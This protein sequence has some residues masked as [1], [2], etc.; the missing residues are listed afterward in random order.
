M[1]AESPRLRS[2]RLAA[3][4]V[5][6]VAVCRVMLAPIFNFA[7]PATANFEGDARLIIW[8]LA[9]DNH[10]LVDGVRALFDA[11]IFY[12]AR[13]ALAY[14]EHLFGISLF[15]LP[16]YAVTRNPV[17]AYNVVWLLSYG[18][19][20]ATAHYVAWRH[21]RDHLAAIV[22]GLAFAFCFF[23]MHHGHGHLHM[24]WSFWIPLSLVAM[25]RWWRVHAGAGCSCSLPLSSCKRWRRGIRR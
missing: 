7:H 6:Y 17:L 16:V 2:L 14:S 15:T 21:T 3:I 19:A 9:W 8:T 23:R 20:A 25:E 12:P 24:I 5:G 22:A 1:A 10:T 11:N 13:N 18:L 4:G